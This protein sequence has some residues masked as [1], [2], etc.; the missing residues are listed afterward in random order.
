[1]EDQIYNFVSA[2]SNIGYNA[3]T[4]T[5]AERRNRIRAIIYFIAV[6]PELAIQR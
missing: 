6:S 2:T 5:E 3:T 1:M 4:P